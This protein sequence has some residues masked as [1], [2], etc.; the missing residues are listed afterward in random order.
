[1]STDIYCHNKIINT[2]YHDNI[3]AKNFQNTN[4]VTKTRALVYYR[5]YGSVAERI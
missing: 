2:I 3:L 4:Y 1:M 5:L